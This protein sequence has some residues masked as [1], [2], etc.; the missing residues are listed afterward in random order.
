MKAVNRS[1]IRSIAWVCISLGISFWILNSN[2][3]RTLHLF[4]SL[5]SAF[6][7]LEGVSYG[8]AVFAVLEY[9]FIRLQAIKPV[10]AQ[11][12]ISFGGLISAFGGGW[13]ATSSFVVSC[14]AGVIGFFTSSFLNG[15]IRGKISDSQKPSISEI[16]T[17][18]RV[19]FGNQSNQ[20]LKISLMIDSFILML[21]VALTVPAIFGGFQGVVL[22]ICILS[23][24]LR[25]S[26]LLLILISN[27]FAALLAVPKDLICILLFALAFPAYF[28]GFSIIPFKVQENFVGLDKLV[29]TLNDS[30]SFPSLLIG[31][32][33]ISLIMGIVAVI[34][35]RITSIVKYV[36][37][38]SGGVLAAYLCILSV[39]QNNYIAIA[40]AL[41]TGLYILFYFDSIREGEHSIQLSK[42]VTEI[43]TLQ[44]SLVII[45]Y[46]R[47]CTGIISGL[48]F[49]ALVGGLYFIAFTIFAQTSMVL[50]VSR[51]KKRD[52]LIF[53]E[54]LNDISDL[55]E[56]LPLLK[57]V[58]TGDKVLSELLTNNREVYK[59]LTNK[60]MVDEIYQL[61]AFASSNDYNADYDLIEQFENWGRLEIG[62]EASI[63]LPQLKEVSQSVFISL[64]TKDSSSQEKGFVQAEA[65]IDRLQEQLSYFRFKKLALQHWSKIVSHWK[66]IINTEIVKL[67][68]NA[69]DQF[70][71]P[72]SIQVLQSGNHHLFKG[73]TALASRISK[74]LDGEMAP[75]IVLF[76]A[77]RFGKSSFL[78]NLNRLLNS[79]IT[80][81]YL[82]LQSQSL[83]ASELDF[84]YGIADAIKESC[85]TEKIA[86]PD[87]PLYE[88]FSQNI[89]VV[90][91]R[92]LKQVEFA[93]GDRRLLLTLD[94][95]EV[96]GNAFEKGR[97]THDLFHQI[98][99]YMQHSR[100]LSFLFSGVETLDALGKDWSTYFIS[101]SPIE[102]SYL[103][104]Y[105]AVELLTNPTPG[106][107][108]KYEEGVIQEILILTRCH[109]F[110]LQL[111]GTSLIQMA[112]ET[113]QEIISINILK[114][115]IPKALEYGYP[116]FD[117]V[118]K[119]FTGTT[120]DEVA[121][122]QQILLNLIDADPELDLSSSVSRK[123]LARLQKFHVVEQLS[124]EYRLEVPLFKQ[125][126]Q[127][128]EGSM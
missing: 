25:A 100:K 98:R 31:A 11:Q 20:A 40:S 23:I 85:N 69:E 47:F 119:K 79:N 24:G 36:V 17:I 120:P 54:N 81:V 63:V 32:T 37:A 22:G 123:A 90:F 8:I 21:T 128:R 125:W 95:F 57:Q 59:A 76:G 72:F 65:A 43:V 3:D 42:Q 71:N 62:Y 33:L 104:D 58:A 4:Q 112:N 127:T 126:L 77:R 111:V 1:S 56:I 34:I 53:L 70:L 51:Y 61:A 92:W 118:W 99:H 106:F 49:G 117:S 116:Y 80:P 107:P 87:I 13:L 94:E 114:Q 26:P 74:L 10:L 15:S 52:V 113:K 68:N 46:V 84:W 122:G 16:Q 19:E 97:L 5:P 2:P 115:A 101:I 44:S 82:D 18:P 91:E 86:L 102:M 108:L 50:L 105:E 29:S 78:L 66:S 73:R 41:L 110:L 96:V 67:K 93:L 55:N 27:I 60:L 9:V 64:T 30:V 89:Y 45:F 109:P 124:G 88:E 83:T 14:L 48:Y 28:T 7:F 38:C 121:A 75:T 103:Q 39:T 6:N 35:W 12:I